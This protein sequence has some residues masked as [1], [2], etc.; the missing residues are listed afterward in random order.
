M[1]IFPPSQLPPTGAGAVPILLSLLFL[2]SFALPKYG[3]EFLSFLEVGRFLPA[4]SG[5]SVEAVPRVDVFLL[6]LWEGR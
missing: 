4:F 3:G 6:Y 5:C 1:E 2:F